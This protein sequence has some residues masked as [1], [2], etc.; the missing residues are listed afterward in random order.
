MTLRASIADRPS[1]RVALCCSAIQRYQQ[2]QSRAGLYSATTQARVGGGRG[3][4]LK[5]A[6]AELLDAG[7]LAD[8][9]STATG[10]RL[11]D[12]LLAL[13]VSEH[14]GDA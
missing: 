7:E 10:Y 12:P 3:G 14:R 4:Y 9:A 8:D 5:Q 2:S 6:V 11:V 1:G 13:W